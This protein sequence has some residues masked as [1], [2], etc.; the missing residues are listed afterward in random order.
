MGDDG[1]TSGERAK[2]LATLRKRKRE[3]DKAAAKRPKR[4]ESQDQRCV[5]V[6][7]KC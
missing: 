1:E 2:R 5:H 3:A 6:L 7:A 4:A